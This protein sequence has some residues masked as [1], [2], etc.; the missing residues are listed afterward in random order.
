[1]SSDIDAL[2][3][4]AHLDILQDGARR[5]L[6]AI[7]DLQRSAS[8]AQAHELTPEALEVRERDTCERMT[9]VRE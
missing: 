9:C 7:E 8:L 4:I 1:M 6:K 2:V 3:H 5:R